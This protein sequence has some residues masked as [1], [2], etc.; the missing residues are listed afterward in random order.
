MN[1]RHVVRN[2]LGLSFEGTQVMLRAAERKAREIEK[3]M[4]VAVVDEGGHLIGFSR[5]D[6]ARTGNIAL[7]LTKAVSAAMRRRATSDERALR[8]DD[9]SHAMRMALAAGPDRVTSMNGG[10]PIVVEGQV[11]GGIGVSNG[12]G[13]QDIAVA[14]AGLDA[15]LAG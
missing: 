8:P 1:E 13:E 4:C 7:A 3:P 15:L 9:P 5:M 14:Q 6:D 2:R 12:T 10:I 11:I